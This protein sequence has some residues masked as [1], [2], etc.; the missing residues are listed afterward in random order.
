MNSLLPKKNY[1]GYQKLKSYQT[2]TLIYDMT[3]KFCRTYMAYR[4]NMSYRMND[5]MIQAARSARRLRS[6]SRVRIVPKRRVVSLGGTGRHPIEH[7]L[8]S[9]GYVL[10]SQE[11][12]YGARNIA[13]DFLRQR[14]LRLWA[15]DSKEAKAVRALAYMPDKSYET[16][17]SYLASPEDFANCL[18]C[19]IYQATY[20]LDKQLASLEKTFIREGGYSENLLQRRLERRTKY[21]KR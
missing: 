1:G 2:A 21:V 17:K 15:K 12:V 7:F 9:E 6:T 13:E 14:G 19:L 5:Q 11:R 20:L 18:I 4:S 8:S 3:V 16:Y 10:A